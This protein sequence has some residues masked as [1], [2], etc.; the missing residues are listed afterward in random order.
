MKEQEAPILAEP[1]H[2]LLKT[3]SLPGP[4]RRTVPLHTC[5]SALLKTA[6][7]SAYPLIRTL[8]R[9]SATVSPLG[10]DGTLSKPLGSTPDASL[11]TI[12]EPK[13]LTREPG[14]A[15]GSKAFQAAT[16]VH[17]PPAMH[18]TS[19]KTPR[20]LQTSWVSI[21]ALSTSDC[22]R[23]QGDRFWVITGCIS[24]HNT[25]TQAFNQRTWIC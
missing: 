4:W 17:K 6:L 11:H 22:G 2:H 3:T 12:Q 23:G 7:N 1:S 10:T 20:N 13:A 24:P 15:K 5:D 16:A 25:R 9:D 19:A 21:R 14:L 18:R 8:R